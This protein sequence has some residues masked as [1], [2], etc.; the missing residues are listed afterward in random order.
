MTLTADTAEALK[1]QAWAIAF[2]LVKAG[3]W[4][5]IPYEVI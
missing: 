2:S 3:V 4:Q 5:K 1:Q